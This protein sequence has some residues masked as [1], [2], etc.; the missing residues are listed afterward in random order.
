[1]FVCFSQFSILNILLVFQAL[2]SPFSE[3]SELDLE[4]YFNFALMWSFGG[5]LEY[6]DR[7]AFSCW[8]KS[9]FDQYIDF[10]DELCVSKIAFFDAIL[11]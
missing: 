8:W 7:D 5:T 10:P 2:I 4:R 9:S 1:M 11:R 6:K 3:L